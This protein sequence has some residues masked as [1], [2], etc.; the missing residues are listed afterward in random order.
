VTCYFLSGFSA[1]AYE[2][3]W[4]RLLILET[5]NSTLAITAVLCVYMGGLGLGS[6]I[7]GFLISKKT[8]SLIRLYGILEFLIGFYALFFYYFHHSL[9]TWLNQL[10]P[11]TGTSYHV[12]II[13]FKTILISCVVL[14]IPTV[15]M[16]A[17]FPVIT[18]IFMQKKEKQATWIGRLYGL[19]TLGGMLG[20]LLTGYL[21][22]QTIGLAKTN[23]VA[24]S[25]N[26]TIGLTCFFIKTTPIPKQI[27]KVYFKIHF[28]QPVFLTLFFIGAAA[29]IYQLVW[30]RTLSLV[31]SS[32]IYSFTII[33]VTILL[34]MALGSILMGRLAD[35]EHDLALLLSINQLLIVLSV[36]AVYLFMDRLP[37]YFYNMFDWFDV[38]IW[39][40]NILQ[41]SVCVATLFIPSLM[42]GGAIPIL[43]KM[44]LKDLPATTA[45][46][47]GL[48][49]FSNSFGAL[50]GAFITGIIILPVL[51]SDRTLLIALFINYCSCIGWLI[52]SP[53]LGDFVRKF[54]IIGSI[55]IAIIGLWLMPAWNKKI[56]SSGVPIYVQKYKDHGATTEKIL[57]ELDKTRILYSKEGWNANVTVKEYAGVT[58]LLINGKADGSDG[59]D[60]DSELFAAYLPLLLHPEPKDIF[61]LGLGTGITLRAV[62]SFPVQHIV[63]SE[64]EKRVVDASTFFNRSNHRALE[65]PRVRLII[66]D[67]R[68]I[69][70][71][72][73]EPYDVIISEPSNPWIAGMNHLFTREMFEIYKK[74]LKPNG[75][76]CQWIHYYNLSP[77]DLKTV[78]R[79]FHSVFTH[80]SLWFQPHLSDLF[81][82]GSKEPLELNSLYPKFDNA[83]LLLLLEE[84]SI[85]NAAT[86]MSLQLMDAATLMNYTKSGVINTDDFPVIEFTSPKSLY[87]NTLL[88]NLSELIEYRK[89]I[90]PLGIPEDAR[91]QLQKYSK[92]MEYFLQSMLLYYR[93]DNEE[94]IEKL[95][96][97]VSLNPSYPISCNM[98]R[99]IVYTHANFLF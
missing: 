19:N 81:L 50:F 88:E 10:F 17:T 47:L 25:I 3:I 46:T 56:L 1:L 18:Q 39:K 65:D 60:K 30:N 40:Q 11:M 68:Q 92:A 95:I 96:Q 63:C 49:Y 64:I 55:L 42:L 54:T 90:A 36:I 73:T 28:K 48:I 85:R 89:F 35:C 21:L 45:P 87:H 78:I 57:E 80:T 51:G 44:A 59:L 27:F 33:L 5:G 97:S 26:L 37:L 23:I 22:I 75:I 67:A 12:F 15:M 93:K 31:L 77:E 29:M 72:Q 98:L 66:N 52:H 91:I 13:P 9:F 38:E 70:S 20:A 2:I 34:G 83:Q 6:L 76:V 8:F 53:R 32:S 74:R 24:A 62:E 79:S 58:S 69:L 7:F 71:H 16:G 41:F 84:I 43:S 99:N 94:Q 61:L 14:G 82:I 86:F 4:S